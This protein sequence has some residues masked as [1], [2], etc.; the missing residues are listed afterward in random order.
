MEFHH[1]PSTN[2]FEDSPYPY[3]TPPN[4]DAYL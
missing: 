4:F 3:D 2:D 1:T